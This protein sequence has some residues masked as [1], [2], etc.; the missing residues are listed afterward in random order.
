M[1]RGDD[2]WLGLRKTKTGI[3]LAEKF[4]YAMEAIAAVVAR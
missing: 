1:E 2:L 3:G 4:V